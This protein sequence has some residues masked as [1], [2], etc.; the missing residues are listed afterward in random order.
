MAIPENRDLSFDAFRG[1]AII[2]VVA[3]HAAYLGG[4]PH[5]SGFLY[6]RQLLNFFSYRDTGLRGNRLIHWL[7]T[8]L[9]FGNDFHGFL[10]R[11]YFG[12]R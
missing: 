12:R 10:C 8:M 9:F 2:A 3:I 6:Y 7:A 4:S 5:S 11:I 1:L